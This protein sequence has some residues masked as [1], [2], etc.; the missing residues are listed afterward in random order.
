MI[1]DYIFSNFIAKKTKIHLPNFFENMRNIKISTKLIFLILVT[2]AVTIYIGLFGI[3]NLSVVNS[4]L[5]TVYNDRVVPLAQLKTISDMYAVNIVDATHKMHNKNIDWLTG[6]SRITKARKTI[7]VQWEAYIKTHI[8]GQEETLKN[9]AQ[10]LMEVSNEKLDLLEFYITKEDTAAFD[11]FVTTELYSY[12]DPITEKINELTIFQLEIAKEEYFKGNEIYN[13]TRFYSI[14]YMIIGLIAGLVISIL[15]I[16]NINYSI[17]IAN[18]VVTQLAK[19]DLTTEIEDRATDEVGILMKN[20]SNMVRKIKE[21]ITFVTESSNNIANAS[22]ELSS[23]SQQM[24]QGASEQAAS[25]EEVSSSME[26]MVANIQQNTQNAQETE[27]IAA[28]AAGTIKEGSDNV[29]KTVTSM[30]EIAKKVSIIGEIAYNTNVLALNAA[31]EAARAGEHGKGFAVVASEVRKL[32]ERSQKAANEINELT[33]QSVKIADISGKMLTAIVPDILKTSNLVQEISSGSNEQNS[34][35][36]QI[37]TAIQQL[38][39]VTQQ[40]A[41]SSE[42]MATS[43]EELAAQADALREAISFFKIDDKIIKGNQHNQKKNIISE[44]KETGRVAKN[45]SKQGVNLVLNEKKSDDD[46]EIF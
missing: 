5:E 44:K 38:N 17:R 24:S 32:A 7:E 22:F 13:S 30:Y 6:K 45:N 46:F 18:N 28:R 29:N 26:E 11:N 34:G 9:E 31:V 25:T 4:S 39:L 37:N 15:I 1:Y 20:L 35:V 40:N 23:A 41:A 27:K 16:F 8:V 19:G 36:D 10:K 3:G 14:L 33:T 2:S 43:S 42:E 12:I 21:I